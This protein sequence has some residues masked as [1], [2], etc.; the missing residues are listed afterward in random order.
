MAALFDFREPSDSQM[1]NENFL[2]G[3]LNSQF[4]REFFPCLAT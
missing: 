4:R 1:P 2:F 3:Q